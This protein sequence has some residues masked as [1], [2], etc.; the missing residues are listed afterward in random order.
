MSRVPPTPRKT[1]PLD[2]IEAMLN[3]S[4]EEARR[5]QAEFILEELARVGNEVDLAPPRAPT[6]SPWTRALFWI[7][8]SVP[9]GRLTPYVVGLALGSMPH[10]AT[11]AMVEKALKGKD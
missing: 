8:F 6:P 5:R 11:D 1:N 9:L 10:K 4:S 7:A 3:V 2:E